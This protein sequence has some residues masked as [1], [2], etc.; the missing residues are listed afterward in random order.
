MAL[1]LLMHRVVNKCLQHVLMVRFCI[2]G[3]LLLTASGCM[4]PRKVE[5]FPTEESAYQF[6]CVRSDVEDRLTMEF[7]KEEPTEFDRVQSVNDRPISNPRDVTIAIL[8]AE[9]KSV[10]ARALNSEMDEAEASA[11][12]DS[13]I[14]SEGHPTSCLAT[15]ME[16][17]RISCTTLF[18]SGFLDTIEPVQIITAVNLKVLNDEDEEMEQMGLVYTEI[19]DVKKDAISGGCRQAPAEEE[20]E[21]EEPF[22]PNPATVDYS[23]YFA[24]HAAVDADETARAPLDSSKCSLGNAASTA[25]LGIIL[26]V[27]LLFPLFDQLL[28]RKKRQ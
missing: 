18:P 13:E 3:F 14:D 1:L 25:P 7:F 12:E 10:D 20:E 8:G 15:N 28:Q 9:F 26:M 24:P 6:T 5:F 11:G 2:A 23:S 19:M 17:G 16:E 4:F 22:N 21:E 27:L